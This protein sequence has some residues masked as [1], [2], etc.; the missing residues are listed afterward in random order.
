MLCGVSVQASCV[1]WAG[2]RL[3]TAQTLVVQVVYTMQV[4]EKDKQMFEKK[5]GHLQ[6]TSDLT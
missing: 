1:E 2:R 3:V 4:L 5:L 6:P